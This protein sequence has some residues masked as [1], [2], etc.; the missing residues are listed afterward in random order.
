MKRTLIIVAWLLM[1]AA[2]SPSSTSSDVNQDPLPEP[3]T[4]SQET[5]ALEPTVEPVPVQVT[6]TE[7]EAEEVVDGEDSGG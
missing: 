3:S 7:E 6:G 2:C 1:L 5:A 4:E